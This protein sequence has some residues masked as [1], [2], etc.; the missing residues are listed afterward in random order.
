MSK[1][2]CK[3]WRSS[4]EHNVFDSLLE[5]SIWNF[6]YQNAFYEGGIRRMGGIDH[7]LRRGQIVVSLRFLAEG[8]NTNKNFIDKLLKRLEKHDMIRTQVGTRG[9]IVTICNY[10]KYQ[11]SKTQVGTLDRSEVG[12]DTGTNKKED[13][14]YNEYNKDNKVYISEFETLWQ[15]YPTTRPKGSKKEALKKY[16]NIRKKGTNHEEIKNG[17]ERYAKYCQ[18]TT[19]YNQHFTTWINQD[20]WK[21]QW[22]YSEDKNKK[23]SYSD[24]LFAAAVK[25][26]END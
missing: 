10:S 11:D 8:F 21:E 17:I 3:A 7:N 23:A 13:N 26:S 12:T 2:Y 20:G 14:K 6:L 4:W 18:A 19:C 22:E 5:A 15:S 16:T 25:A 1:G 24:T 9:T